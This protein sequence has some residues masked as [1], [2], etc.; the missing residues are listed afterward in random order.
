MTP[1]A[2]GV[3]RPDKPPFAREIRRALTESVH[4]C[5]EA[6]QVLLPVLPP[7]RAGKLT[8]VSVGIEVGD[9]VSLGGSYARLALL[10]AGCHTA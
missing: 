9:E 4:L 8:S 7:R 3:H 10:A 2:C 5:Q 1:V 6:A